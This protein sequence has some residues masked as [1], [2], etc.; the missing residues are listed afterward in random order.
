MCKQNIQ[1]DLYFPSDAGLLMMPR[2]ASLRCICTTKAKTNMN[3]V[4]IPF[5][6]QKQP[7]FGH[8]MKT[9]MAKV[10]DGGRRGVS[11]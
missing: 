1:I 5:K 4:V 2:K 3:Y 8:A 6:H 10:R 11:P 9:A 7:F